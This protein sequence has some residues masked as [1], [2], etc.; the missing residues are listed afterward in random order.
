MRLWRT[1]D[2]PAFHRLTLIYKCLKLVAG[3]FVHQ[4][5]EVVVVERENNNIFLQYYCSTL[6]E[7]M[8]YFE[9]KQGSK[10]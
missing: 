8:G 7:K 10:K 4:N 9:V 5:P 2:A 6:D 3:R 1:T